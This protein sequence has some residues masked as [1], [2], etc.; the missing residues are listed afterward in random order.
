[1]ITIG[2]DARRRR[3]SRAASHTPPPASPAP[4]TAGRQ[5]IA[6]PSRPP[7]ALGKRLGGW[8]DRLQVFL[9]PP[10]TRRDP[11][12]LT[13]WLESSKAFARTH[14]QAT[15]GALA[16]AVF[17]VS[18][19]S[20]GLARRSVSAGLLTFL[21]AFPLAWRRRA[22]ITVFL[23]TAVVA[24]AQRL[25][26]PPL[27]ADVALLAALYTVAVERPRR[28]AVGAALI[29]EGGAGVAAAQWGASAL[30]TFASLSGVV[31]AALVSG[32][33]VRARRSHVAGL[34]ERAARLEFERDQQSL[35]AAA[36][37]RAR[38]SRE[39]HDVVAH[40]LAVVISLANGATAKLGRDP[41]QS[42]EALESISELGRQALT[43]TRGLLSA[44]RAG[45]G[46]AE[47]T[48]Q[49]G[50]GQIADLVDRAA[51]TGLAVSLTV[52]GEPVPVP[53]GLALS[54]Y[55]IVQEAITNAVK[56]AEGATAVA[57][58]LTWTP[59]CLEITVTDDGH[60]NVRP[61]SSPGGFGL[62]GMRER[63]AVHGG[64]AMAGPGQDGGWTVKATIPVIEPGAP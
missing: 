40:S 4:C 63:A 33:Y 41:E 27:L 9:D 36:A 49:P 42:R 26:G 52:R 53:V 60:G 37:E 30:E 31:V 43:D 5:A 8:R 21:L 11:G 39:M 19:L 14:V 61:A 34:V 7:G 24:F 16:F 38:I 44:L 54:A 45:E 32:L 25:A 22:P 17:A 6:S 58:G 1:V 57:V 64:A 10:E 2:I 50:I 55:R 48:P 59:R 3:R 62:A 23:V 13:R 29:L 18:L 47:R 51:A 46:T 56:H 20:D 15:D 28:A 35:L 12:A